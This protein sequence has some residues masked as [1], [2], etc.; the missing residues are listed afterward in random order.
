[1]SIDDK[2]EDMVAMTRQQQE[3]RDKRC[4]IM[5]V[6]VGDTDCQLVSDKW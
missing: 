4:Q 3:M 6:M 5:L 1:M 2:F